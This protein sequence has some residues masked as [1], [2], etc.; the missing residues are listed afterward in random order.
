MNDPSKKLPRESASY[1]RETNKFN[2][3][4]SLK[5]EI[6]SE[7]AIVGGGIT[8]LM[9]AYRLALHG[10]KPVV[11]EAS[12]LTNGTTGHTTAKITAQH[13]QIYDELIGTF[14]EGRARQY[15]ESNIK[16]KEY[17]EKIVNENRIDCDFQLQDAWLYTETIKGKQQL[18][19]EKQ[20][21]DK[22]GIKSEL[23][24]ECPLPFPVEAAL[25]MPD[26][27]QFHPIKFLTWIVQK[28]EAAGVR[29]FE[30]TPVL[31]LEKGDPVKIITKGPGSVL[32]E[33]VIVTSHFPFDDLK[34]FYFSRLH[35]ERSY[36]IAV[37]TEAP[38]PDGMFLSV[39]QP[40]RSF[41][42]TS[43]NGEKLAL[44]GGENHKTGKGPNTMD[45]FEALK[46]FAG[47]HFGIQSIE[48]RWSAQD[49]T[50]LDK[51][52]YVGRMTAGDN[53]I[54]VAT[55]FNKWGMTNSVNA[56]MLLSDIV[57]AKY[58]RYEEL[59]DPGRNASL[60]SSG[61]F[62]KENTDVAVQFVKTHAE[63]GNK[64]VEDVEPGEGAVVN[65]DGRRAGAYRTHEGDLQLI[66]TTCTHM[67]CEVEWNEAETSWDCPCHGSRFT[68]KGEVLEGPANLPL[69]AI[70]QTA[71]IEKF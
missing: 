46:G 71:I 22:L 42:W 29:I 27:A 25:K 52:P 15:Y 24:H 38:L 31:H 55:G 68:T 70:D 30:N 7:I 65:L 2:R 10:A 32:A 20:A 54:F 59:Y 34:G 23:K 67:G 61:T 47:K 33:K 18:L 1:W 8:G 21:Y 51:V 44:I 36:A 43:S 66:D 26:Q 12:S 37:R 5:E 62:V 40:S 56:A 28:L 58:N 14:G 13:G 9:T 16:A 41:R 53:H 69:K 6:K 35:P 19:K 11:L 57:S 63:R 50:T 4:P 17:V 45:H 39:G 49:L 3:F 48:S 64:S 60:K